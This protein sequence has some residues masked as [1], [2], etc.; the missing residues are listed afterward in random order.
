MVFCHY[1]SV[2]PYV[3]NAYQ[4]AQTAQVESNDW[5]VRSQK[6]RSMSMLI[7]AIIET[8]TLK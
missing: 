1:A 3:E 6:W 5:L 7:L 4:R 8:V 2:Q